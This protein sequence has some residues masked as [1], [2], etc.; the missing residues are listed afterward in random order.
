M[1]EIRQLMQ[2]FTPYSLN[3]GG[4]LLEVSHPLVMGILN[5]TP[6]SF[7]AGCR[8]Q[9]DGETTRRVAQLLEEGADIIDVGA[10][11]TRPGAEMVTEEEEKER[12]EGALGIIRSMAPEALVSVDT[13]RSGIVRWAV[14]QYG[15]QMVNDVSGGE[16]DK[17][18]FPAVAEMGVP[19]VL[20]HS[21]GTPATMQVA[22]HY[23]D[24][25]VE[26]MQYFGCKVQQ[27]HE[28]GVCDIIL[29]PGFGFG[30][31]LDDN[32]LL[33]NRLH[34][35]QALE[36]PILVGLSRK[37]MIYKVLEKG[38]EECLNGTTVLNTLALTQGASIL[39]V[40]DVKEAV[41]TVKLMQRA[42]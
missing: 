27:L 7:Y 4:K 33:L 35:L 5:V 2:A 12:L 22:P 42:L 38:P 34:D 39:R 16:W 28:M 15:V 37:S 31:T 21:Q 1:G 25:L 29:D 36:M 26:M 24:L 40:H 32:Y 6:D 20:T 11:S 19:Y 10:C 23:D 30:K 3:M 17:E 14:G 8:A 41:E 9:T 18:M 13:F